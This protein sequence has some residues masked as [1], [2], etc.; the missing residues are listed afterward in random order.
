MAT[1]VIFPVVCFH[2]GDQALDVC[3]Q[4]F[5]GLQ[6]E[7]MDTPADSIM[8]QFVLLIRQH[9]QVLRTIVCTIGVAMMHMFVTGQWSAKRARHH[10]A[11]FRHAFPVH[12]DK[13]I[14]TLCKMPSMIRSTAVMRVKEVFW[15][16]SDTHVMHRAECPQLPLVTAPLTRL[17][18]AARNIASWWQQAAI[19]PPDMWICPDHFVGR[20][21]C[22][23]TTQTLTM[24]STP[25]A[26]AM[27]L[28]LA[29]WRGAQGVLS[30]HSMAN[31][32]HINHMDTAF[33]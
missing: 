28:L 18:G 2:L 16:K 32:T 23:P 15:R 29:S 27:S 24:H 8:Q 3:A 12:R 13:P 31:L 7:F 19:R 6:R 22:A 14:A 10:Q 1:T 25:A 9:H 33:I 4:E 5:Q 11:M 30:C 17:I 21:Q 20:F 26:S